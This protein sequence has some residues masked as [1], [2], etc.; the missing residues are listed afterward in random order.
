MQDAGCSVV[1]RQ[2]RLRWRRSV[3]TYRTTPLP[4]GWKRTAARVLRLHAGVCHICGLPGATEVDHVVPVSRG[5]TDDE[6]NLR[7]AHGRRDVLEGR[8][9]RNCHGAKTARESGRVSRK[10]EPEPHPGAIR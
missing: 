5:G 9:N 7:P 4:R 6:A 8:S 10:R 1:Y 2:A 3:S